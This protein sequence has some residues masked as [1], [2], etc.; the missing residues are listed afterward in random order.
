MANEPTNRTRLNQ[1]ERR[2]EKLK[3]DNARLHAVLAEIAAH[4]DTP[5]CV[6]GWV[7]GVTQTQRTGRMTDKMKALIIAVYILAG[8]ATFGHFTSD[9]ARA[10]ADMPMSVVVGMGW[11]LYASHL[12]WKEIRNA[13]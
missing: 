13:D 4:E 7:A 10:N 9:P 2:V 6:V 11:P 3:A 1:L 8:L 12:I 5:A